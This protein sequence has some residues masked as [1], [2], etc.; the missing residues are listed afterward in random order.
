MNMGITIDPNQKRSEREQESFVCGLKMGA[1]VM[2]Y[3][4]K[5][6]TVAELAALMKWA[7][8]EK[9]NGGAAHE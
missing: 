2:E 1:A 8:A 3:I 5:G 9:L 4:N 6:G 7:N